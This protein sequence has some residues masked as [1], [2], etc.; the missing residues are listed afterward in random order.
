MGREGAGE[1][2]GARYARRDELRRPFGIWKWQTQN[3][4]M[5]V[6]YDGMGR[7]KHSPRINTPAAVRI[8]PDGIARS[9]RHHPRNSTPSFVSNPTPFPSHHPRTPRYF[10]R[11]LRA[12]P[13]LL[14][15][16]NVRRSSPPP[17]T[18]MHRRDKG[19]ITLPLRPK[20]DNLPG[21]CGGGGGI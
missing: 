21:A 16:R 1:Q 4:G 9:R 7:Y 17:L 11:A 20:S 2:G 14:V 3:G 6:Q 13:S 15:R 8:E 5:M 10:H 19:A 12:V 18:S